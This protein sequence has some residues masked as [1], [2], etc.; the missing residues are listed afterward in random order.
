MVT[1]QRR[2]ERARSL[3]GALEGVRFH[4]PIGQRTAAKWDIPAAVVGIYQFW[5]KE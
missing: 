2:E 5:Q 4:N 1:E 3:Q